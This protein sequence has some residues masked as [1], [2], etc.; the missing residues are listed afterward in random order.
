MLEE[1]LKCWDFI[2]NVFVLNE[3]GEVIDFFYGLDDLDNYFFRVVGFVSECFNEDVFWIMWGLC[4]FV[5]LNFD[6][7]III[8]EVMKKYVLLLEKIF[9]ECFFIEFD[10]FL[11]VFYWCKGMLVL[12]DSYVFNY[13]LCLKNREL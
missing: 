9:V 10:K 6:I 11:L 1:D 13:L 3:D 8:F 4:F 2:V 12:I 5:S 7:E